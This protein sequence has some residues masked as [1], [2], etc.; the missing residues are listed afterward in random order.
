LAGSKR[1]DIRRAVPTHAK[2]LKVIDGVLAADADAATGDL[3]GHDRRS[4]E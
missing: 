4:H 3:L 1:H 2:L